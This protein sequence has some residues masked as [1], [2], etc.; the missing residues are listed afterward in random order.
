LAA[1]DLRLAVEA[2]DRHHAIADELVEPAAGR[3]DGLAGGAEIAVE[4]EH[5]VVGQ[6]ASEIEVKPRMSA[7]RIAT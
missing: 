6:L 2:E 7:N 5:H 1:G 3:L 4:Q